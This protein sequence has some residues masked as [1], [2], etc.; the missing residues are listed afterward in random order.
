MYREYT[1]EEFWKLYKTLPQNLK[2]S[3]FTEET[4]NN[5]EKACKRHD[6][7]E[8]FSEILNLTGQV[9]LGLLPIEDFEKVLI[10]DAGLSM[11]K[12]KEVAREV[13]RFVF[14]P[15][16]EDLIQLYGI[17]SASEKIFKEES[18]A[19]SFIQQDTYRESVE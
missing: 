8:K 9:L 13:I 6:V 2:D 12:S 1:Q 5:V 16:R 10:R 19:P 3:L 7:N 15:I 11:A 18:R 17:G 14:F 4:G